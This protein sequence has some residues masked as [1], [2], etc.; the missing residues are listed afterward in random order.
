[1]HVFGWGASYRIPSK[2]W[3]NLWEYIES[4]LGNSRATNWYYGYESPASITTKMAPMQGLLPISR[5]VS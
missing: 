2:W 4:D 5:Q 1:M 3:S